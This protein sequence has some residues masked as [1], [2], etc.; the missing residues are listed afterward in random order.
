MIDVNT[1]EKIE[2]ELSRNDEKQQEI[3]ENNIQSL[4]YLPKTDNDYNIQYS[5]NN[6]MFNTQK[7]GKVTI[8]ISTENK[9]K[10]ENVVVKKMKQKEQA[11]EVEK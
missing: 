8:N 7:I 10:I 1:F 3:I 6:E 9:D 2:R 11:N 5:S 4:E